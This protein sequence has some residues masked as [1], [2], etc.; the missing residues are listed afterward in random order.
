MLLRLLG[1]ELLILYGAWRALELIILPAI[2]A[3]GPA[4]GGLL[5]IV[6]VIAAIAAVTWAHLTLG[7]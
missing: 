4:L 1:I 6:W 2:A 5:L 7:N 3:L